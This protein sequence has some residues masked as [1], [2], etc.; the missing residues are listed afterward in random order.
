MERWLKRRCPDAIQVGF[1]HT[2]ASEMREQ[3]GPE[4][5]EGYYSFGFVRNPWDRLVSWWGMYQDLPRSLFAYPFWRYVLQRS[6]SFEEFLLICTD[7]VP[8]ANTTESAVRPQWHYFADEQGKQIVDFI[9]R[10]ENLQQDLD[11]VATQC[12]LPL[13]PPGLFNTARIKRDYREFYTPVLRD[14]IAE[15]FSVD[16]EKFGYSF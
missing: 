9:G 2:L 11:I 10:F 8:T 3:L 13:G 15:R 4:Q 12:G 6:H 7:A 16:I 14:L 1:V 5:W